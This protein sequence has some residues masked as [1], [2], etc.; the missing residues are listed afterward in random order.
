MQIDRSGEPPGPG[1]GCAGARPA[2][3]RGRLWVAAG[4]SGSIGWRR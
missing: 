2:G 4:S 3:W 1:A